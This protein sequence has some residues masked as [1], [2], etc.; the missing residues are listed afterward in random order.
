MSKYL[1]FPSMGKWLHFMIA[2]TASAMF[3][4]SISPDDERSVFNGKR[5]TEVAGTSFI[6]KMP[7]N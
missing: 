3:G 1:P 4:N 2:T 6:L 7:I 5:R